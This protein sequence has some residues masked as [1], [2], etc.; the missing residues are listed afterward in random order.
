MNLRL[1]TS[2]ALVIL[3][4][5]SVLSLQAQ[6]DEGSKV[7]WMSLQEAIQ[8]MQT[9]QRPIILDFY[10]DWCGWCKH[11][12]K[13]TYANEGLAGYINQNFYPVSFDAESKDTIEFLGQIYKPTGTDKKAPH[14]LAVKLLNGNLMYPTTLFLNGFEKDKN[15]FNLNLLVPGYLDIPK[16][17]PILIFTLEGV[18]KSCAY[19][20]FEKL[21]DKAMKDSTLVDLVKITNW[22]SVNDY[23]DGNHQANKKTIVMLEAEFC[24]SCKIMKSTSFTDSLNLEYIRTKFNCV[25]FNVLGTDTIIFKGQIFAP[26]SSPGS[27]HPF[28]QTIT[29]GNFGF[30]EIVILD[31]K[32]EILDAIPTYL[33]PEVLNNIL[34]FYGENIYQ[35]KPWKDYFNELQAKKN[36]DVTQEKKSNEKK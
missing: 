2:F 29:R 19:T 23:L 22:K 7:K 26:E 15:K 14:E 6:N 30:P 8:K 21:Y 24:N 28:V 35:K 27:L 13:T 10:T 12:M 32:L 5:G 17:E 20:D 34:R 11:M 1:K 36:K 31:E 3:F 9:Q 18:Y 25:N 33:N 16:I 4:V